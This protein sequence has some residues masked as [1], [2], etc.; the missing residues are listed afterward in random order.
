MN[1]VKELHEEFISI[2]G[3]IEEQYELISSISSWVAFEDEMLAQILHDLYVPRELLDGLPED[4]KQLLFCKM[5]EEQV[6]RYYA[7][8]EE[9]DQASGRKIRSMNTQKKKKQV[10]FQIDADGNEYC[11]VMEESEISSKNINEQLNSRINSGSIAIDH[12]NQLRAFAGVNYP[13][14]PKSGTYYTVHRDERKQIEEISNN[15]QE[16]RRMFECLESETRQLALNKEIEVLQ[17]QQKSYYAT[18]TPQNET[19]DEIFYREL[20][21]RAKK[22]DQERREIARRARDSFRRNSSQLNVCFDTDNHTTIL[23]QPSPLNPSNKANQATK[24]ENEIHIQL[25]D[26]HT[27]ANESKQQLPIEQE[28][29]SEAIIEHH[30]SKPILPLTREDIRQWFCTSEIPYATF[31]SSSG[32]IYPWFH[33][34]I[35]RSYAEDLL[36]SKPIGTYLIRINEK[37]FGYALSYRASDHC[38]HLLI[39]VVSSAKQHTYRFLGGAKQELFLQLNELIEKYSNTPIRSN[40]KDVL[41]YPCGQTNSQKSDYADL[42]IENFDDKQYESLYI[43]LE[44]TTSSPHSTTHL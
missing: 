17:Q 37:I 5:R 40:S 35:S 25:I 19:V 22:A 23:F 34:I 38:R 39:E 14:P 15:I 12:Q 4:Q 16:A 44:T 24:N 9:Q 30:R 1:I 18:E 29:C 28:Q 3:K 42:F 20:A 11:W 8:D 43:S 41:R 10:T 36:R 21:E 13:V 33:G 27:S 7:R 32:E 26:K 31:R 2:I 6:R